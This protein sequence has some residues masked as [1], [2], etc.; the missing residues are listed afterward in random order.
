MAGLRGK[1][2][3]ESDFAADNVNMRL[4]EVTVSFAAGG[5]GPVLQVLAGA[6]VRS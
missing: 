2:L 6:P 4:I 3:A 1:N 5:I